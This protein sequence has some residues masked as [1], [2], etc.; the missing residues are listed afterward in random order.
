MSFSDRAGTETFMPGSDRPLLFDTVPP[1]V[2][3]HTTSGP[4]TSTTS[5]PTRPSSMSSRS[6]GLASVA[7]SA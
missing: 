4:S 3:V 5:R 6:P 2:T 7:S 1:I